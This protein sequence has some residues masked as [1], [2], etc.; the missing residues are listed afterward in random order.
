MRSKV[1]FEADVEKKQG[2][3]GKTKVRP[4]LFEFALQVYAIFQPREV[5]IFFIE[6]EQDKPWITLVVMNIQNF[7][8]G[9]MGKSIAN[10][11][12][13]LA[14]RNRDMSSYDGS[15]MRLI[16][17]AVGSLKY[18]V[19]TVVQGADEFA[20]GTLW[21]TSPAAKAL[22]VAQEDRERA[23]ILKA[24]HEMAGTLIPSANKFKSGGDERARAPKRER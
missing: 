9:C 13:S 11:T 22:R 6:N 1:Y 17:A 10:P 15:Q 19:S 5:K 4:F 20:R 7:A 23:L 21:E 14:I 18:K 2:A 24:A 16:L 3:D 8:I 12:N